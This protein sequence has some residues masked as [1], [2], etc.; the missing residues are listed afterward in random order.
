MDA[1]LRQAAGG[2]QKPRCSMVDRGRGGEETMMTGGGSGDG[3]KCRTPA[4]RG[5]HSNMGGWRTGMV[6]PDSLRHCCRRHSGGGMER[7]QLGGTV[8]ML[9]GGHTTTLT[10]DVKTTTEPCPCGVL[11]CCLFLLLFACLGWLFAAA[12]FE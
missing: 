7:H 2:G 6:E 10:Q 8:P 3:G 4:G 1:M 9:V 5:P 12:V 11:C